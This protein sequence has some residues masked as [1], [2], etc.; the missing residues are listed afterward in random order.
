MRG[1]RTMTFAILL[2]A[3]LSGEVP[4]RTD[5]GDEEDTIP[6]LMVDEGRRLNDR[7]TQILC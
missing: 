1:V 6:A 3:V 2:C 4:P 7:D 5:G